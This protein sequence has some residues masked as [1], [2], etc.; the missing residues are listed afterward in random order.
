MDTRK[1]DAIVAI[2]VNNMIVK[3]ELPIYIFYTTLLHINRPLKRGL[4]M[5]V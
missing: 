2:K 3:K 4:P 1:R 5:F